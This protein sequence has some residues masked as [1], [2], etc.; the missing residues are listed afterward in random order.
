MD[1][2]VGAT[3]S[4]ASF[5]DTVHF[6]NQTGNQAYS[7]GLINRGSVDTYTYSHITP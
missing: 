3:L 7:Q 2:R 4:L 5:S 6:N 1:W